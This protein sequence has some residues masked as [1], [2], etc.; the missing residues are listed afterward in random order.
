MAERKFKTYLIAGIL[1]LGSCVLG[2]P[3]A[4]EAQQPAGWQVIESNANHIVLEFNVAPHTLKNSSVQGASY[5]TIQVAEVANAGAVGKPQLPTTGKMIA[6]PRTAVP[7]LK[8]LTDKTVT[9]SL[10][11]PILPGPKLTPIFDPQTFL[12]TDS[13]STYFP[14][15]AIYQSN[16][17][18][19]AEFADLSAPSRW[20]SQRF[21]RLQ[22]APFQYNPV[23]Q[24]LT[25]H[26]RIRVEI[27][28]GLGLDISP[29][30]LGQAVN[31]AGFESVFQDAFVNYGEARYWRMPDVPAFSPRPPSAAPNVNP[32]F[33]I[34]VNADGV[35]RVTCQAL[36]DAGM[37]L[38]A[39]TLDKLHLYD[40]NVELAIQV[41]DKNSNNQC[42][43]SP[44]DF[45]LFWGLKNT[46]IYA[47]TNI[48]WLNYGG[49]SGKRM[50]VEATGGGTVPASFTDTVTAEKNLQY[51]TV[52]PQNDTQ[53]HWFW[54]ALLN[55]GTD[56]A[57]YPITVPTPQNSG[58]ATLKT[59]VA[60]F[61]T[62]A[63]STVIS[64]NG[65][66]FPADN[67]SGQ[68]MHDISITFPASYLQAG[69]NT[70]Q[71]QEGA[72][73]TSVFSQIFI[74]KFALT[75]P[76]AFTA[77]SDARRYQQN[78]NGS[79][80]YVISGFTN[81]NLESFD[82]T[83]PTNVV[84]LDTTATTSDGGAT[85]DAHVSDTINSAHQYIT[86]ATSQRMPPASIEKDSPSSLRSLANGADYL[87]ITHS[88]F[89]ASAQTLAA[90]RAPLGR[91]KVVDVQDVYD[92]FGDGEMDAAAI[93][94]F[95]AFVYANWQTP[96][97][98]YVVLFGDGNYD[99]KKY[100]PPI[101][102]ESNYIP[103]YLRF[104]D[105]WIGLTASDYAFLPPDV[106][107]PPPDQLTLPTMAIGRLP[108]LTA[109]DADAMVNKI[110]W[111]EN[112]A[113]DPNS[114]KA[115]RKKITFVSDNGY[116]SSGNMDPAGNFWAY[117][118]EVAS[119]P[120]YVPTPLVVD[121]NYYNPCNPVTYPDY[122]QLPYATYPSA[123]DVH[124]ALI[125]SINDGRLI[126]NYVGH[127]SYTQW[128]DERFWQT[129]DV[130]S[131]TNGAT[132]ARFPVFL[133]MTCLEGYFQFPGSLAAGI[134]LGEAVV[135]AD[136]AGA[137]ASWAPT[138]FG[139]TS[140][141]DFFDRGFF[142]AVFQT[143]QVRV[144]TAGILAK[145]FLVSESG[146]TYGDL[147]A[148]LNLLGDPATLM[149][150]PAGWQ[151]PVPTPTR[152]NT[153]TLTR[154][155]TSTRTATPTKT[156]TATATKTATATL[157]RTLTATATRTNTNTPTRTLT[158]TATRTNTFTPTFTNTPTAT[159]TNTNT[160]TRTFTPMAT[161]TA[162]RT[163]TPT[164]T[165]TNTSTATPTNTATATNTATV[166]QTFT[167]TD[168]NAPTNT[169]TRTSTVTLTPTQTF[170]PTPTNTAT[171]TPTRTNTLTP[172]QT[173]TLTL[174][175]T[176]T[177]TL[178]PTRTGTPT[179][180]NTFVPTATPTNTVTRTRAPSLTPTLTAT[181]TDTVTPTTTLT[182]SPTD[183]EIPSVTPT[184]TATPTDTA[185]VCVSRPDA[186]DLVSPPDEKQVAKLRVRLKW[187][188]SE[189]A[190]RYQVIVRKGSKT[191]ERIYN[192]RQEVTGFRTG[193]LEQGQTY[194]WRIKAC[195][196][197]GCRASMWS[198]FEIR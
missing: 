58:N 135:R 109:A 196:G 160:P 98:Q 164:A 115:W 88:D 131:L 151:T 72:A 68:Q 170:T 45:F 100:Y 50:A 33:K 69:S 125:N 28:Y 27:D 155:S 154:T 92:E 9:E 47:D 157:T 171:A 112:D 153:A 145:A 40:N 24:Q 95:L 4:L 97:T 134:S 70:I 99:F 130:S 19:P 104:V 18:Y 106:I 12:P 56:S 60:G 161:S 194:Y 35:Y 188:D 149:S 2:V 179:P 74:D 137:I 43:T 17:L 37:N 144:G 163:L 32:N 186:P 142:Q 182:A 178:T 197:F 172:T 31:E 136:N 36:S 127:G 124:D 195:N 49:T 22:L 55:A 62:D 6:I 54:N 191:G 39:F 91:V 103:P 65:N 185:P 25:F 61:T 143:G 96:R 16:S 59:T 63:H 80:E 3:S 14:N 183:T 158:P 132:G 78:G 193:R 176:R 44:M 20:R 167:P 34:G 89:M 198:N 38:N 79:F 175:S 126:V 107:P 173:R 141:H 128:G 150:M 147:L 52:L 21:V 146:N 166:T 73:L 129:S 148:T 113:T 30:T 5:T 162:T 138:G 116:D 152:T 93:A 123:S 122:C 139:V 75:Y 140:G 8:I 86:L 165:R 13:S 184:W 117:S 76:S 7:I 156:A 64:V 48:Y 119:D 94:N 168:P 15:P 192:A 51:Y 90:F 42:D 189:C 118:D 169:P 102:Q 187:S 133:P 11:H 46:S 41:I 83:D 81:N 108:A 71:V 53:E 105:P 10:E 101:L 26:K 77:V 114:A 177:L 87:I 84:S 85:Y 121:R 120:Y 23:L 190:E 110:M 67:W 174:T 1:L 159:R 180:T 57:D 82:V 111:Y 66:V 181:P 29:A